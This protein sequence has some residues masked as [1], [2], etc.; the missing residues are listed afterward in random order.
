MKL[1]FLHS[2]IFSGSNGGLLVISRFLTLFLKI[3]FPVMFFAKAIAKMFI[4]ANRAKRLFRYR[5]SIIFMTMLNVVSNYKVLNPVIIFNTV[6][7]VYDFSRFKITTNMF[8]HYQSMF[9]N[10]TITFSKR[11]FRLMNKSV[12][13][14]VDNNS[15]I[16]SVTVFAT[17]HTFKIATST[18]TCLRA[19]FHISRT[20]ISDLYFALNTVFVNHH[21]IIAERGI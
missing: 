4:W 5:V 14:A 6:Q 7:M 19:P 9:K 20:S 13:S 21:L 11:M 8:F 17:R 1:V 2:P 10:I 16:P 12:A 3:M 18:F 15:T